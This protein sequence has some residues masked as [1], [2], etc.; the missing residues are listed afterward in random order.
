M[1][2]EPEKAM[3]ALDIKNLLDLLNASEGSG[4]ANDVSAAMVNELE[5]ANHPEASIPDIVENPYLPDSLDNE[6]PQGDA[7]NRFAVHIVQ[8]MS[9]LKRG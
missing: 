1:T 2:S 5:L 4:V 3:G 9:K 8:G 7:E 6:F